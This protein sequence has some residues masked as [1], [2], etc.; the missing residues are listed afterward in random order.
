MTDMRLL[1]RSDLFT[2]KIVGDVTH[3]ACGSIVAYSVKSMSEDRDEYVSTI[4]AASDGKSSQYTWGRQDS[5]PRLS[6]DGSRLAFISRRTGSAQLYVMRT[7][8]GEPVRVTDLELGAGTAVWAPDSRRIA[9][10]A[11]TRWESSPDSHKATGPENPERRPTKIIDRALYKFDGE[12][13]TYN[14]R[15]AVFIVDLQSCEVRQ[16]TNGDSYDDAPAWSPDGRHIAFDSNRDGHWDLKRRSD[17]WMVP[18]VGG[19]AVRV[20]NGDG[21]WHLPTFSPD[22]RSLAYVG[23][24]AFD[25]QE[26]DDFAQ[27]WTCDRRGRLALNLLAGTDLAVG[28]SLGSDWSG[29]GN[30]RPV[31]TGQ[32]IFFLASVRGS[33]NIYRASN[34]A[35]QAFTRGQQDVMSFSVACDGSIAY[36][37]SDMRHPAEVFLLT[38]QDEKQVTHANSELL[39][40]IIMP[41]PERFCVAGAEGHDIEGWIFRPTALSEGQRYPLL[42]YIHGGPATAYGYSFFF[43][44]IWWASRGYG[45][46]FCNPHG[47]STYG[48]S[49]QQSIKHDWGNRDYRDIMAFVDAVVDLPWVD[50]SRLAAAGGSYGGFMV[51]W[52]AGHTDRFAAFCAQ[53]SI[54]NMVSQGGTSD[55]APFRR[56]TIGGTPE[57]SAEHLWNLSPLKYVS[58]VRTPTLI[59]HQEQDHRCPIEQGEQW[60]SA[61]KRL[62][63]PVRFVRFPDESHGMSRG[64][65]PSR[66]YERLGLMLEWFNRYV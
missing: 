8:G 11:D 14:R 7:D 35:V 33:T 18:S 19:E 9:F 66:R 2:L 10:A 65:K 20:T 15:S 47:S 49:F 43:E 45:V 31:W 40:S 41:E 6:P 26:P 23:Y 12:G 21:V 61:L 51:N 64:G 30:S 55:I 34:S 29:G 46:A 22:G 13:Y 58:E 60:F 32:G 63:V 27:L 36:S 39:D 53:R 48:R 1:E 62:N 5:E 37:K 28:R 38:A 16:L 17:I 3:S 54:C 59:L 42:L 52:L 25:D 4:H 44:L 24:P 56:F 57:E 50:G